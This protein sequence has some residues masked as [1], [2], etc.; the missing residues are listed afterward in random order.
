[1]ILIRLN[2]TKKGKTFIFS[3]GE[4]SLLRTV[5]DN[6]PSKFFGQENPNDLVLSLLLTGLPSSEVIS[7][8]KSLGERG[9]LVVFALLLA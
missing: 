1:M 9:A 2:N 6:Q 7:N 5:R 8:I 3:G 4:S